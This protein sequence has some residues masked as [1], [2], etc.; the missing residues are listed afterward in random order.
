MVHMRDVPLQLGEVGLVDLGIRRQN[1]A[2][3]F[4]VF[5]HLALSLLRQEQSCKNGIKA[6]RLKA[7]WDNE[8]L[9]KVLFA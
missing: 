8:Y 4:A 3:N 2:E 1:A 5:R 7:G 6:K 9:T